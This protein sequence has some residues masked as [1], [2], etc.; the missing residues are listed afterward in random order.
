M[1]RQA[2]VYRS[3]P[4]ELVLAAACAAQRENNDYLKTPEHQEDG[5]VSKFSNR[6]LTQ[7]FLDEQDKITDA[8]RDMAAKVKSYYAGKTFKLLSGDYVNGFTRDVMKMLD[9]E[10]IHEG[11]EL[12]VVASVPNSY[13]SGALRDSADNRLKFASGGYLGKVGERIEAKIEVLKCIF[14]QKWGVY[15]VSAVTEQD[16]AVFFSFKQDVSIFTKMYIKGTVKRQD[17]NVTQL[18]RVKV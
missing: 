15:F 2:K 6:T 18:N 7:A 3:W 4:T 11:Y 14:S 5:K 9:N 13:I 12:A 10:V 17:N 1:A 8:D 16:Q